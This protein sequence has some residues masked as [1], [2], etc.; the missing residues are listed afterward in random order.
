MSYF[1]LSFTNFFRGD[2]NIP[3]LDE[4]TIDDDV[5]VDDSLDLG[6]DLENDNDENETEEAQPKTTLPS[7]SRVRKPRQIQYLKE[8]QA[9]KNNSIEPDDLD[10]FFA[11]ACKSTRQLPR[12]Y[13]KRVKRQIQDIISKSEENAENNTYLPLR[14]SAHPVQVSE[15][16]NQ[17]TKFNNFFSPS[18]SSQS[19]SSVSQT[20]HLL[21][22]ANDVLYNN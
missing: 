20:G 15:H 13:Q 16:S 6:E 22:V 14:G 18:S 2:S 10:L 17:F 1:T 7:E 11:S 21:T 4:I 5:A 12:C 3:P 8:K 19:E 9:S